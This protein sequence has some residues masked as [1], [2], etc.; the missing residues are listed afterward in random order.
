MIWGQIKPPL[1]TKIN[2]THPMSRNLV[3]CWL[4][5]E[6]CG[7]II[8]DSSHNKINGKYVNADHPATITSGW[9][10]G[11]YGRCLTFDG[12]N[13]KITSNKPMGYLLKNQF[14]LHISWVPNF[15]NLSNTGSAIFEISNSDG[16]QRVSIRWAGTLYKMYYDNVTPGQASSKFH[17]NT[18][19]FSAGDVLMIDLVQDYPGNPRLYINGIKQIPYSVL[20]GG[21]NFTVDAF[22]SLG[23]CAINNYYQNGKVN[24]AMVYS[25]ALTDIE[26]IQLYREPFCM[27]NQ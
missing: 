15:N 19:T 24:Y 14:T 23:Y 2:E 25:R 12:S 3:G 7:D 21:T 8:N 22:M 27:F 13:D 16:S 9:N 18:I 4:L 1:G 11:K 26:I 10:T 17:P 20:T 5:N 6:Q